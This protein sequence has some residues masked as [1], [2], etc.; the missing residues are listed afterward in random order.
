MRSYLLS[1]FLISVALSVVSL[2]SPEGEKGGMAKHLR[3]LT[4]LLLICVLI[5]PLGGLIRGLR[6]WTE[7][8]FFLP[9]LEGD[10]E[11]DYQNELQESL[12]DASRDYFTQTLTRTLEEK[13]SIATGQIRCKVF[14]NENGNAPERVTVILS[15]GAIWKDPA[16]IEEFVTS[17]LGC[18]CQTAIE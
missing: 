4:S 15:G 3:L 11:E 8:D 6:D 13:F 7:G 14:W 2:L 16:Q 9:G 17:L 12:D 10:L 5:A 18:P 1:V